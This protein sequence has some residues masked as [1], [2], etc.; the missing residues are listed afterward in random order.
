MSMNEKDIRGNVVAVSGVVTATPVSKTFEITG[1]GSRALRVDIKLSSVTQVGTITLIL[2][3]GNDLL[4]W[5]TTKASSAVTAAGIKTILLL[6]TV[7]ADQAVLPLA[8][9][10]RIVAT[11]TNSSDKFTIDAMV[12]SQ[13]QH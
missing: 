11:T 13:G 7:A 10:G 1:S 9:F 5:V 3:T 6:D 2:Q 4:G 8:A 12:V